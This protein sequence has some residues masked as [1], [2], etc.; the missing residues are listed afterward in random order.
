[1]SI[2][3]AWHFS[4]IKCTAKYLREVWS[5]DHQECSVWGHYNG[6]S[7]RNPLKLVCGSSGDM[8]AK[9][10][11]QPKSFW[12]VFSVTSVQNNPCVK[13]GIFWVDIFCCLSSVKLTSFALKCFLCSNNDI[14]RE[15]WK[16]GPRTYWFYLHDLWKGA[17]SRQNSSL[18]LKLTSTQTQFNY[19]I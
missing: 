1:M 17:I 2:E 18:Q 4:L 11:S 6:Q 9:M 7:Y 19:F 10:N 5:W 8:N 16:Y 14:A 12:H 13:S 3:I 15:I